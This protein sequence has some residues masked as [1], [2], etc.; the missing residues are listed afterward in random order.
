M[1]CSAK[2]LN[3]HRWALQAFAPQLDPNV[4]ILIDAGTKPG[5][6]SL[7]KLWKA[8]DRDS[9]VGGACGEICA[10]TGRLGS[11][12]LNPLVAAQNFEYKISNILDKP[13]ESFFGYITVLPGAFSAYR[14]RALKNDDLGHGPLHSYFKGEHLAGA[15]A[16]VFTSNMYLAEDRILCWELVAKRGEA[17]V[18]KYVAGAQGETDVPDQFA[19]FIS[20][21]RRWLNGSFFASAYAI[22]KTFQLRQ[23]DHSTG[24]KVALYIQAVYNVVN[25]AFAWFGL[26]SYWIFFQV[27]TTSL[28][29]SSFDIKGIKVINKIMQ[30][31]YMGNVVACFLFSMGNKPKA[32][33][34][35]Y[36]TSIVLFGIC[37]C[38]MYAAA[39]YCLYKALSSDQTTLIVVEIVVSLASTYGAYVFSSLIA[40][41]VSS[42]LLFGYRPPS[43]TVPVLSLPP[44]QPAHLVTSFL[45]YM[46]LSPVY[47][48]LL[49]IYA[50]SNLHDFSWGTKNQTTNEVDLGVSK[51]VGA[52]AVEI[53][54][55]S[56]QDDVDSM[57]DKAIHNIRTLPMI[58][59][60]PQSAAQLTEAKQEYYASVRTNVLLAWVLSNGVL[61]ITILQGDY[62]T[63][64]S[65]GE[66]DV[67]VS[68]YVVVVLIMTA[69]L[70]A[71]RL[72]GSTAFQVEYAVRVVGG[73]VKAWQGRKRAAK[74]GRSQRKIGSA[75]PKLTGVASADG[76]EDEAAWTAN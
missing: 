8:F 50:F 7:Y 57:Y 73:H 10:M 63:T 13:T 26:A 33:M 45:Q 55:P 47:I 49:N 60:A 66:T 40:L 11:A 36:M 3:S 48:N 76:D 67:R 56:A 61:V 59:P 65:S 62:S 9:N 51:K 22:R 74:E 39:I 32:A 35:K 17:W 1:C 53:N 2:K 72:V 42:S 46:L 28:E 68:V 23:S 58:V 52:D 38:Y 37:A 20:Q 29:D 41:D 14:W 16:D 71:I 44:Q 54:L 34:W 25:L 6:K 21:R 15:D 12:L 24:K 69:V 4:C 70:A 30:A 43:L 5:P 27:L 19:E 64:F 75:T 31:I 18:L